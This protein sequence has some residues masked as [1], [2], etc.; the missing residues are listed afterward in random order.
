MTTTT[1]AAYPVAGNRIAS[2]KLNAE[3]AAAETQL[4]R[5]TSPVT[6]ALVLAEDPVAAFDSASLMMQRAVITAL[7]SV[8]LHPAPR[9]SRTFR[10]ETVE[11]IPRIDV[12]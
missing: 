11:V 9:G 7:C 2:E 1:T 4:S 3:L 10:P 8:K 6:A 5:L 12:D